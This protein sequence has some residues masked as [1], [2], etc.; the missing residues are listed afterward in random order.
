MNKILNLDEETQTAIVEPGVVWSTLERKLSRKGLALKCYPSSAPAATVGG[1]IA[2][3]GSGIGSFCN[4][5]IGDQVIE[6]EVVTS[7]V[8]IRTYSEDLDLFI[9]CEGITG[10]ISSATIK[11]EKKR[12]LVPVLASFEDQ[13]DFC[14]AMHPISENYSPYAVSFKTPALNRMT[15][16]AMGTSGD[17]KERYTILM[18]FEKRVLAVADRIDLV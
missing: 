4:G 14:S 8:V 2:Y 5:S 1:W 18:A 13:D 7:D 11:V 12:D 3:G 17:D 6:L 15:K 16:E 9:G 10:L